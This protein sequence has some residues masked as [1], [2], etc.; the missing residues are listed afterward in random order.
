MGVRLFR[1]I[2]ELVDKDV[3]SNSKPISIIGMAIP[4]VPFMIFVD[5]APADSYPVLA[6]LALAASICWGLFVMW[7]YLR[8]LQ[9]ELAGHRKALGSVRFWLLVVGTVG[10]ILLLAAGD[11]W[12]SDKIGWPEAYGFDCHGRG[13]FFEN[14]AHSPRLLRGGNIYELGL[15]ALFWLLPA[16]LVAV[17]IYALFKRSSRRRNRFQP[18]D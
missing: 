17:L 13:C 3:S 18:L 16:F 9:V 1:K 12:L 2:T 8:H 4:F 6:G 10:V 5:G 11:I 7:R 15:F 14:L